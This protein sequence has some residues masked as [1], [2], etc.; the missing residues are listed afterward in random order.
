MTKAD[1]HQHP[2]ARRVR[3]RH[4][5]IR[6]PSGRRLPAHCVVPG[7]D[8]S[9][10]APVTAPIQAQPGVR[11]RSL[12]TDVTRGLMI[13][14]NHQRVALLAEPTCASTHRS[15]LANVDGGALFVH[16]ENAVRLPLDCLRRFSL[17]AA[18]EI[19]GQRSHVRRR[20]GAPVR[21]RAR[22]LVRSTP[23]PKTEERVIAQLCRHQVI[24]EDSEARKTPSAARLPETRIT[25]RAAPRAPANRAS[26]VDR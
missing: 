12:L 20:L 3:Q 24:K 1:R 7:L 26:A 6:A 23:A 10:D 13:S 9:D 4:A 18:T 2:A 17:V 16:Q 21:E 25:C 5:P 14:S 15:Q 11:D 8:V 22:P 19:L